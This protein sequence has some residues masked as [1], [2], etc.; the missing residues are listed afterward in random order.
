MSNVRFLVSD[1]VIPIEAFVELVRPLVG[2]TVALPWKG[3]G[4]AV[5]L[6]LG[7]L[8][9]VASRRGHHAEGEACISI[10]WDWRV[11]HKCSVVFGSSNTGPQIERGLARLQGSTVESVSI[12]G[13]VPELVVVFSNEHSLRSMVMVTG[14]PEWSIKLPDRRW[15]SVRAGQLLLGEGS[16]SLTAE[17]ERAFALAEAAAARWGTPTVE[18]APGQCRGC[19]WLVPIDGEGHLLDYGVCTA[20]QSPFDGKAV[21]CASG[22]PVYAAGT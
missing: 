20:S 21:H 10:E 3:Y 12:G 14:D 1:P 17:E 2:L 8:A 19:A 22:C 6:E 15:L 11:E 5:F 7:R 9:S 18:P 13:A 4:S 16:S